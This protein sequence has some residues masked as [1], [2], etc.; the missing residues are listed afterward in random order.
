MISRRLLASHSG[1]CDF[2]SRRE[3]AMTRCMKFIKTLLSMWTWGEIVVVTATGVTLVYA[4]APF[5]LPF[6]RQRM[7]L[8]RLFRLVSVTCVKLAPMWRFGIHGATPPLRGR[9]V[10]ISNHMSHTDSMLISHLP[11]EMKWLAK[12]S[13]FKLPFLGWGMTLAGDIPIKRDQG[14]SIGAAMQRCAQL[15]QHDV[16]CFIFPEGTRS[17]TATM[18]PFKDGAFRLAIENGADILPIAVAGTR[19]AMPKHSWQLDFSRG[20]VK[21]GKPISTGDMTIADL[22]AL[23]ARARQEIQ[24][25]IDELEP[26]CATA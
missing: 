7:R 4:L 25:M 10:V 6:D 21:V 19:R 24:Q 18:L 17:T 16:P 12:A 3:I 5:M 13:L 23:K 26:L 11:Y 1:R 8:G 15:L 9:T 14:G 2:A 20:L 22:P